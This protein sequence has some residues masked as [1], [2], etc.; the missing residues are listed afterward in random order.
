[1]RL[2]LAVLLSSAALLT[3]PLVA[4]PAVATGAAE[5]A[6]RAAVRTVTHTDWDTT[7]ELRKGTAAGVKVKAGRI[8]L[9]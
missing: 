5:P 7:A 3:A 8:V 6:A 4:V 1:M 2:P 9:T